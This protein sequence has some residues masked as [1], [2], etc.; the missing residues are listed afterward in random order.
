MPRLAYR[1]PTP[2]PPMPAPYVS[3]F[4]A[5]VRDLVRIEKAGVKP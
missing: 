1:K 3:P 2:I 4:Q 5:W